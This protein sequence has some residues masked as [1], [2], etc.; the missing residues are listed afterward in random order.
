MGKRRINDSDNWRTFFYNYGGNLSVI[1]SE[2]E[3][4]ASFGFN[5][6]DLDDFLDQCNGI[7]ESINGYY[8]IYVDYDKSN[9][10]CF[11]VEFSTTTPMD[12]D[13]E[14]YGY[15]TD[16]IVGMANFQIVLMPNE[17]I[18]PDLQDYGDR[19]RR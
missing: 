17:S 10:D 16:E 9:N 8:N 15:D 6:F 5:Q 7:A 13:P 2:A 1:V 3:G 19:L 11:V 18:V 14:D 4:E 12:I